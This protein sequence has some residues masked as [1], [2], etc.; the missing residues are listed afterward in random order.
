MKNVKNDTPLLSVKNLRVSFDTLSGGGVDG[1]QRGKIYALNGVNFDLYREET[2]AIVGESGSGKSQTSLAIM[3]ILAKNANVSGEIMYHDKNLLSMTHEELNKIRGHGISMI[4]QDPMT[5]LNPYLRVSTQ[6]T[7]V[8]TE[9]GVSED[10]ARSKAIEILNSLSIPKAEKVIDNYPYQFSGGM[11]Q[12][13]MIAMSLM[14]DSEIIIADEPTTALDVT[15]QAQILDIVNKLKRDMKKA[16]IFITHDLGVVGEIADKIAVFYAGE[17]VEYGTRDEIFNSPKHPYTIGL[18][19]SIPSMEQNSNERLFL[20]EG[21]P[22]LLK[23]EP[24]S[25]SFKDRCPYAMD[26][27]GNS[28][29]KRQEISPTH[30][31]SCFKY[32][33]E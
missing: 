2:L 27:C 30:A 19:K 23:S 6:L 20:I 18:L 4:F 31:F 7:E 17:I 12:R 26:V 15:I 10:I 13:I 3:G 33:K 16:I 29:P 1:K 11:R 9:R 5:S 21:N 24:I 28:I 22:P 14:S 25:C 8:L 32:D